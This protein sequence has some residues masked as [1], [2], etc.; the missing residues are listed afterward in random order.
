MSGQHEADLQYF[1]VVN[2]VNDHLIN[3]VA[4]PV[5]RGV[6]YFSSQSGVLSVPKDSLKKHSAFVFSTA[7]Y[8]PKYYEWNSIES[9]TVVIVLD[10]YARVVKSG[11]NRMQG[12]DKM[13]PIFLKDRIRF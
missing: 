9:D 10:A 11:V 4:S 7:R 12:F 5:N 6:S 1:R 8:N 13:R 3:A 2:S